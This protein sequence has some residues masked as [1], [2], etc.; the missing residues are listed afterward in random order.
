[1]NL[2]RRKISPQTVSGVID[3]VV[4]P[5]LEWR[6]RVHGVYWTALANQPTRLLPGDRIQVVGRQNQTLIIARK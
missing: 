2:N 1:M 5:E 6:V 4:R 3:S